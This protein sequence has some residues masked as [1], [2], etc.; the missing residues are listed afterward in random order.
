VRAR[1]AVGPLAFA[2]LTGGVVTAGWGVARRSGADPARWNRHN[3]RHREVSLL[4]GPAVGVGV[5]TG[6]CA[7][8]PEDTRLALLAVSSAAMVG[9]Y[10]DLYGDRHAKGLRGHV[11]AL[12]SGRLT[13]G[14]V[15]LGVMSASA[16]VASLAAR[17]RLPGG[18]NVVDA[19]VSTVLVA[20]G[21]NLVNLLDLRPGR[22][23]KASLLLA[24]GLG[25]LGGGEVRRL[26]AVATGASLAALPLDLGEEAM[27]GDAGANALGAVLGWSASRLGSR[28]QRASIAAG[29]VAL[30][31][32]SERVSFSQ[33]IDG[34]R[35]LR[36]FD[37]LGRQ[38]A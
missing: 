30:T 33:V 22:A 1:Q 38:P 31:L 21:A 26:A 29:A 37:Q 11:R 28:G 14:M 19:G 8:R 17:K 7:A 27:L 20:G 3:F 12:G 10:D 23:V 15:K 34:N 13:T 32:L 4:L 25:A 35:W 2:A 6:I 16:A 36:A 5:L 9:A 18:G 24:A